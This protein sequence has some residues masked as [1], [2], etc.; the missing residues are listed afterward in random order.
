MMMITDDEKMNVEKFK[1][2][3]AGSRPSWMAKSMGSA[4]LAACPADDLAPRKQV[5]ADLSREK[6]RLMR[7]QAITVE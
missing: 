7:S 1:C 3:R 2:S 6:D 5:M 4:S